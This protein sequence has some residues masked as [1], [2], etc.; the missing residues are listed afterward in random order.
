MM[1]P[2]SL[3]VGVLALIFGAFCSAAT[4]YSY[5]SLGRLATVSYGNGTNIAY[6]YD[7]VGTRLTKVTTASLLAATPLQVGVV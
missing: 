3:S 1:N 7:A 4:T 2:A 5:D 6:S